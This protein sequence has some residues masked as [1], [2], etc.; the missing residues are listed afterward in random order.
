MF[1]SRV[2]FHLLHDFSAT[3]AKAA[4]SGAANAR[5]AAVDNERVDSAVVATNASGVE[6]RV[7]WNSSFYIN[8]PLYFYAVLVTVQQSPP[9]CSR[10][11][12][13]LLRL[14]RATEAQPPAAS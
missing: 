4:H 7:D 1:I 3:A 13:A 14:W 2:E 12:Q 8:D 11:T 5:L 9:A 6:L 10:R